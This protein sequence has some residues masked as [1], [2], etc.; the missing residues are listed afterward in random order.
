MTSSVSHKKAVTIAVGLFS[1]QIGGSERIGADVAA[2]LHRRGYRIICFAF[3]G[4]DG[5][6][7]TSL[8]AIGIQCV[9][10]NYQT[11]PRGIRR[12]S[13]QWELWRFLRR[14]RVDALHVHHATSLI[15]SAIPAVLARVPRIV[16]TEH[17]LEALQQ[18][19]KYR[20]QSQFYCRFADA[21]SVVHPTQADYFH[22]ELQ[23]PRA[24]VHYI[25]N[26][27]DIRQATV[28]AASRMDVRRNLGIDEQ[29][30]VFMYA[31]R[32]Q[33]VK[34][35]GTLIDA[36]TVVRSRCQEKFRLVIVGDGPEREML[37]KKAE[38]ASLNVTF[39]GARNDVRILLN[40]ADCFVMTSIS[41]GLP[42]ALLEAMAAKVPCV[43]T[44]VGGIPELF[45]DQT[46]ALIPPQRPEEIATVLAQLMHD[47]ERQ[48]RMKEK[49]FQ[50]VVDH[51]NLQR[52]VDQFEALLKPVA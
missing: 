20:K 9:D 34:D 25:P 31:G 2:E 38:A 33:P 15:L 52:S 30:F 41:E 39:L 6:I 26:G 46:D 17:S 19:P 28:S 13:Y 23:V 35:V 40:A 10:L 3:Y 16:M 7:R 24:R 22:T 49:A 48:A 4:S 27:V 1:F 12:L 29:E 5:P 11:R 51:H 21:I 45:S 42:M 36:I 37:E 44:A 43:A 47:P 18:R 8:E 50:R 32:L 14:N